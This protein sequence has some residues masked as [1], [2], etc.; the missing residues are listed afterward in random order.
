MPNPLSAFTEGALR[1]Q[2]WRTTSMIQARLANG[3]LPA[4]EY[5]EL[6]L[7]TAQISRDLGLLALSADNGS[8]IPPRPCPVMTYPSAVLGLG[9]H[10]R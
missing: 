7:M 4:E 9:G 10:T 3:F 2:V 6:Q 5:R 1:Q 8:P